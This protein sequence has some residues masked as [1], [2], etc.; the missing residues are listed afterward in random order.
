MEFLLRVSEIVLK[1]KKRR[2]FENI[3]EK[4]IKKKLK[5]E[6]LE[7]KNWGGVYFLKTKNDVSQQLKEIFGLHN[8]SPVFQVK[9]LA[10]VLEFLK[11]RELKNFFNLEVI[12]GDKDFPLNSI[13]IK[14]KIKKFLEE[15]KGIRYS[16]KNYE[17]KIFIY[18][19]NKNFFIFFEKEKG[20]GGL[21]V[22]SSGKGIALLSTG[23]DSPVASFL[24]MKRGLKVYFLHFHSYPQTSFES[25][26][27]VKKLVNILNRFNL[28]SELYLINILE[29]QKFYYLNIPH[30]YLVI[31][32]RRTMMRL[33]ERLKNELRADVLITGESLGQVASQTIKNLETI[34]QAVSSLILRP[35]ISY[36]KEE[37]INLAKKIGTEEIS[38]LPGEDCCSLFIPQ[39]VKTKSS[40]MEVLK[41][42]EGIKEKIKELEEMAFKNKEKIVY[43]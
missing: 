22:G 5:E 27:K 14:E 31:F 40:L 21:P 23:F 10:E 29:I 24:A 26:E 20:L 7:L 42:E 4:N 43:N 9:D 35:L 34:S 13:Q 8:F 32:Y 16:P 36:D 37:I 33:A 38:R 2:Y 18:Y 19:K 11:K 15:E 3:F 30:E 1:R 6:I 28:G 25:L 41:I 39:R 17:T 12:R